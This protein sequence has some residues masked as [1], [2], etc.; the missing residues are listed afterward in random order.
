MRMRKLGAVAASLAVV[1]GTT[2]ILAAAP[3]DAATAT[4]AKLTINGHK[5]AT[6]PYGQLVGFLDGSVT[7][8]GSPVDGGE[9]DLQAKTPGKG[10]K[11]V[12]KDTDASF[13]DFGTFG[14][15]AKGNVAYR[16]RYLGDATFA[17]STSGIVVV[18]TLWK[19]KNTSFCP[20]S[21]HVSGKLSPKAKHL[22]VTIE[23]K[24]GSWKKYKVVH[25][26]AHSMFKAGVAASGGK[27]TAY[28]VIF[29]GTKQITAT[30]YD[31]G[32][33]IRS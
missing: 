21:C 14:S 8:S 33:A 5:K 6:G 10:W 32:R 22:K 23:V 31:V 20:T 27:G 19:F 11:T 2:A 26:N 24:H 3:A 1:A 17:P 30:R 18:T 7:S 25:T 12:K 13:L 9:A 16:V 4:K 15:K 28:R 29:A